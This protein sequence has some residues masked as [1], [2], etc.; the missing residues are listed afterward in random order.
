MMLP[1]ALIG[2]MNRAAVFSEAAR[3]LRRAGFPASCAI[4]S[5]AAA[6]RYDERAAARKER[7][8]RQVDASVGA[9]VFGPA[10]FISACARRTARRMRMCVPQRHQVVLMC[11]GESRPRSAI[12]TALKQ[13]LPRGIIIPMSNSR[14]VPPAL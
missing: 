3:Q 5:V 4:A 14:T 12:R 13:R 6:R 2:S 9:H 11:A 1:S 7:T 10:D 8:P